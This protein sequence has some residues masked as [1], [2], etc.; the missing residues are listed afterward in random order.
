LGRVGLAAPRTISKH[1][2]AARR[3]RDAVENRTG[4]PTVN[5]LGIE[6]ADYMGIALQRTG[7]VEVKDLAFDFWQ[8]DNAQPANRANTAALLRQ[9][10]ATIIIMGAYY[11]DG[12]SVRV[13]GKGIET[14]TGRLI[15]AFDSVKVGRG[16]GLDALERVRRA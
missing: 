11:T 5:L 12:D 4:D 6:A 15:F 8:L 1:R 9:T 13:S 10:G 14:K 3:R 7:L 16:E 2:T